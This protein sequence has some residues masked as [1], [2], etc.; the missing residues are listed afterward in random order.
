MKHEVVVTK[1]EANGE[2]IE[3]GRTPLIKNT[4][5]LDHFELEQWQGWIGGGWIER[6]VVSSSVIAVFDEEG[7]QK[8]MSLNR[9]ASSA[10]RINLVGTVLFAQ[11]VERNETPPEYK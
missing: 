4:S 9:K 8:G 1:I 3:V 7:K 10:A 5:I 2:T 6:F 11:I